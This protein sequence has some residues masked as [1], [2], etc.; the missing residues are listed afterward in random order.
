MLNEGIV[1]MKFLIAMMKHETNTFS[2]VPTPLSRFGTSGPLWGQAAFDGYRG[3]RTPM[4]A[5]IDIA[6]SEGA[7]I[8]T[9]VAAEALP[10]GVVP[11][12][13][14]N[15]ICDAICNAVKEGCD[16]VFLDLHGAM[17][18]EAADDGEGALLERIR[19]ISPAMP[20]AVTLDLHANLTERI[21]RNC[22]AIVGYKTYPHVDMYEAGNHAGTLVIRTLK[23]EIQPKMA[24]GNRPLLAH[25]LR[26]NSSES[27]MKELIAAAL[28]AE[29]TECLAA[30]VF[31]G[32][33]LA[34]IY[35]AGVSSV[36]VT[37]G[38]YE[39]AN[40]ICNSLL[41]MAWK[42]RE[43]FIYKSEPLA[44]S[45][46]RAGVLAN[47]PVLLID[48]ADN[49][50]SGATQDTMAVVAEVIRQGLDD[51]AVGA[52]C[53]PDAVEQMIAAGVGSKITISLGGKIDMP[54]IGRR[55]EPLTVTGLVKVISDGTFIPN[56]PTYAGVWNFLGRTAVLD[57][58]AIQ[59][60]VISRNHEP[61]DM[62]LFRSVGI[63]PTRKKYLLLK[64]RIYYRAGFLPIARHIVEC[65]GVGVA[66]SDYTFFR[67]EK[68][69]RPI[70]PLDAT[71]PVI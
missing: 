52:I 64:S 14:Y 21:V 61:W 11:A 4:G 3:T 18:T 54:A 71:T 20:I 69:R 42:K 68:I 58:G 51:V 59:F 10:S 22:T 2:P 66:S 63:E 44:E 16:A 8:I 43:E 23:G 19:A 34:D 6:G 55:G 47:G 31:G 57:T 28:A 12:D 7:Q 65:A 60:V 35:D 39:K 27:P 26:M 5:Y 30:T 50:A 62:G 17:V 15:T 40:Q 67:F 56:D 45:V 9:P 13:V 49:C 25:T 48:H 46:A 29:K 36:V 33:P 38:Q 53:D 70:Y 37:D 1:S 24:W 41:E 32:F